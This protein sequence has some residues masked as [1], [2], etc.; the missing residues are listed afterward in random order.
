M[1][2]WVLSWVLEQ[3]QILLPAGLLSPSSQCFLTPATGASLHLQV[4]SSL[5][6]WACALVCHIHGGVKVP[7]WHA[8]PSPFGIG[9]K[10]VMQEGSV[11]GD[12]REGRLTAAQIPDLDGQENPGLLSNE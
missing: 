2:G 10:A 5:P 7:C 4:W 3:G 1:W 6:G 12:F 11:H 9:A 8:S